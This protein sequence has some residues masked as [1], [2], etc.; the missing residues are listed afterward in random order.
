MNRLFYKYLTP[1]MILTLIPLIVSGLLTYLLIRQNMVLLEGNITAQTSSD[2]TREISY[3]NEFIAKYESLNMAAQLDRI[4]YRLGTMADS[5]DFKHNNPEIEEFINQVISEEQNIIEINV[6][7]KEGEAIYRKEKV[8]SLTHKI[9]ENVSQS[10]VFAAMSRKE[11]FISQVEIYTSK[12]EPTIT[13]GIPILLYNGKFEGG[14]I[15]KV[16]LG[17]LWQ[18]VASKEVGEGGK[19]YVISETGTLITHPIRKEIYQNPEFYR[20]DFIRE[21]MDLND[22]TIQHEEML[23]SFATN[24]YGWSTIIEIPIQ[25]ALASVETSRASLLYFTN[26]SLRKI[27]IITLLIVLLVIV[28]STISGVYIT[29]VIVD[30]IINLTQATEK[31]SGGDLSLRIDNPGTDEI[32][33]LTNSFNKM[34]ADLERKQF[35]LIESNAFITQ[36]AEEL[37]ERYNSDLE[38]FARITTHD[39]LEPLRTIT[40]YV[41]LIEK[42][43]E[44]L[45]D[46][47]AKKFMR[48]VLEGVAR[49]HRIVNDLFE[50]SHIRTD[51]SDFEQ[52]DCL[53]VFD[54]V[55]DRLEKEITESGANIS[56]RDLPTIKAVESNM[57]LVFQ[58]L[59]ANA[60]KFKTS[61]PLEIYVTALSEN[62]HWLFSFRDNGIGMDPQYSEKIFEIFKRLHNQEDYP[63]SGMGLAICKNIV[64][65]HGG[66]IWVE[67]EPE[68]GSTFYFTIKKYFD[69]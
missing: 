62:G 30:P 12:D 22:G 31:I 49:M 69:K 66:R 58:N 51:E 19:L 34:T 68:K 36:H 45:F 24:K 64:E 38:Q 25:N 43:Y 21:I 47:K 10:A 48:Y 61:Q 56:C 13:V 3:K 42:K 6:V 14:I 26:A 27:L 46:E 60:M 32:G 35:Q 55:I 63:G 41:Q 16:G 54:I 33:Q 44:S 17:F 28:L 7:D 1:L 18:I 39:L 52:V 29:K 59:L 5:P 65:R 11:V 40:S 57:V 23:V 15:A 50:Y 8:V 9:E 2:L 20:Y 4:I 67:S 53:K 37:R